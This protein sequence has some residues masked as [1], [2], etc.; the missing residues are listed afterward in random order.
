[1]IHP[2]QIEVVEEV[3]RPSDAEVEYA[4]RVVEAFEAAEAEGAGAVAVDGQMVDLPVVE[5]AR[6]V[7]QLVSDK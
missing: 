4:R 5:R 3:F 1:L 6:R 2:T 7:L